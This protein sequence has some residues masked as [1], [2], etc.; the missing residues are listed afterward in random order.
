MTIK[1]VERQTGMSRANVRFYEREGLISPDRRN[2]G[3]RDYAA[4]DVELLGRIRLLRSAQMPLE[5]IRAMH[6]GELSLTEALCR[7]MEQL[8]QAQGDVER[9]LSIC[10]FL[11]EEGAEYD[12][13][14]ADDCIRRME[15]QEPDGR[16]VP[17]EV[18]VSDVFPGVDPWRRYFARAFDLSLYQTAF[19]IVFAVAAPQLYRSYL[20]LSL[21][22]TGADI[23][24]GNFL[25]FVEALNADT[26]QDLMRGLPSMAVAILLMLALEPLWLSKFGTTPGKWILGLSV[27]RWDGRRMTYQEALVRS[28]LVAFYGMGLEL[29]IFNLVRLWKSYSASDAGEALPW[30]EESMLVLKDKRAWRT[31][32]YICAS[33]AETALFVAVMMLI[34]G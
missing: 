8:E 33:V 30:E 34:S 15:R 31:V 1:E 13:L 20:L 26:I 28:S 18:P 22:D 7:L 3:Y 2:N 29:P 10:K 27:R 12:S 5:D 16:Y 9:A 6:R 17:P 21:H 23:A 25:R 14:D 11:C 19:R 4:K 32:A 24:P